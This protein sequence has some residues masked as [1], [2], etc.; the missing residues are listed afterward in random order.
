[1]EFG[2]NQQNSSKT[3]LSTAFFSVSFPFGVYI[4]FSG[5]N[6]IV[7]FVKNIQNKLRFR[8]IKCGS[9]ERATLFHF[10]EWEFCS[11]FI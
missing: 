5:G 2:P 1:M 8:L 9:G 7:V 6:E 4:I 3:M 11:L 10:G